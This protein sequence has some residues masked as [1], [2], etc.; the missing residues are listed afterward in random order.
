[1]LPLD[2]VSSL[3]PWRVMMTL[4]QLCSC[5]PYRIPATSDPPVFSLPLCL[6]NVF[7]QL[8]LIATNC[9]AYKVMLVVNLSSDIGTAVYI[10]G[11]TAMM[12]VVC[13]ASMLTGLRS[14]MLAD[15]LHDLSVMKDI[16]PAPRYRW[17]HNTKTIVSMLLMVIIAICIGRESIISMKHSMSWII[18]YGPLNFAC[19]AMFMLPQELPA[20]VFG[21]LAHRLLVATEATV[22]T[23]SGLLAPDGSFKRESDVTAATEAMRDLLG[24]SSGG[25]STAGEGDSLLLPGHHP[26]PADGRR[27]GHHRSLRPS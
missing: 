6:W 9:N 14:T 17:Y 12:V 18:L 26:V 10:Y 3:L 5:F 24:L 22:V 20:M 27:A 11:V 13:V 7:L 19:N 15:M 2:I 8:L 23:V 16:S 21:V 25:E 4:M 1:M